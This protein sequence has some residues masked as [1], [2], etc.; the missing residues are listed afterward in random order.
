MAN[1]Q[2]DVELYRLSEI[3]SIVPEFEGDQI[4]LNT[5]LNACDHAHG[6]AVGD[7]ETLLTLHIKNKLRGRAAQLI[8]SR[9]PATWPEIKQLL[10]VHFG[11]SRDLTSLIQDLQRIKQLQ[12]ESALT[13]FSRLQTH[14]AKMHASVQKSN[15]TPDQ[16]DAQSQL[17]ETMT[18]NTLLTGLEPRLGQIIRA[19]NPPDMLEASA[20]IRRELQ[21][22]YFENQKFNKPNNSRDVQ[23]PI[24][25]PNVPTTF[26]KTCT[27]C[28]RSGHIIN[29]CRARQQSPQQYNYPNYTPQNFNQNFQRQYA[30]PQP[31]Q[32]QQR[33]FPQQNFSNQNQRPNQNFNRPNQFQPR[34]SVIQP[35]PNFSRN[36]NQPRTHHINYQTQN[37]P[38]EEYQG[39][40][41]IE[42][43]EYPHDQQ[44]N[45]SEEQYQYPGTSQDFQL[46]PQTPYDPPNYQTQYFE[47]FTQANP[48]MF[49]EMTQES[50]NPISDLTSQIQSMNI[51]NFNPN[52]NF[53]E[54]DFI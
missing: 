39:D 44:E 9:N 30:A 45:F 53:P 17:I 15:L 24:R 49:P 54:Q 16:K 48:V 38:S 6:M 26:Q 4:F 10:S 2:Q 35:N 5:F 40:T 47:T 20:R 27:Y 34:P 33:P 13:F 21:L 37:Y 43:Q 18:L 32:Q 28:K 11:D 36:N 1:E 51:D 8:N 29:E 41:N 46:G 19:G 50:Y 23:A 7:Q 31:Q 52:L 22:S 12:N 25:K 14:N 42:F 3:F